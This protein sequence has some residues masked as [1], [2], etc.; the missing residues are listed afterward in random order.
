MHEAT[1]KFIC[2]Y[3]V[4]VSWASSK[5]D[6]VSMVDG[7]QVASESSDQSRWSSLHGHYHVASLLILLALIVT[8]IKGIQRACKAELAYR[9]SL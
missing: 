4:A 5:C 3:H 6:K 9:V 7:G 8:I 1:G 2:I